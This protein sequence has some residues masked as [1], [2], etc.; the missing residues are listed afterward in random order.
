[1][2]IAVRLILVGCVAVAA[3]PA[4]PAVQPDHSMTDSCHVDREMRLT[5][6]A[7]CCDQSAAAQACCCLHPADSS[8]ESPQDQGCG[9]CPCCAGGA[10][11]PVLPPGDCRMVL[12]YEFAGWLLLSSDRL[13]SRTERPLLPPPIV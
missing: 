5:P 4:A 7:G 10:V 9:S 2:N 12:R 11:V 13:T 6:G 1:M 3:V 8:D